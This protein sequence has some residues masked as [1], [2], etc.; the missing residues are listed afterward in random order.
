MALSYADLIEISREDSQQFTNRLSSL[1]G[2]SGFLK[3]LGLTRDSPVES[4]LFHE[5]TIN[6]WLKGKK[7]STARAAETHLRWWARQ[8]AK[9]LQ[10]QNLPTDRHKRMQAA[11]KHE[12]DRTGLTGKQLAAK[13]GIPYEKFMQWARGNTYPSTLA[14]AIKVEQVLDV[15]PGTLTASIRL[16]KRGQSFCPQEWLPEP[17]QG[18]SR[19]AQNLRTELR[20]SLPEN[21]PLLNRAEQERLIAQQV[22]RILDDTIRMHRRI[23]ARHQYGFNLDNAPERLKR[24]LDDF[25]TY[26][27]APVLTSGLKRPKRGL[28]RREATL[29]LWKRLF[30]SYFG[31]YLLPKQISYQA[32]SREARLLVGAGGTVEELTMGLFAVPTLVD[33]YLAWMTYV[34]SPAPTTAHASMMGQILSLL[35]AETGWITQNPNL[36]SRIPERHL[37]TYF[38]DHL[39]FLEKEASHANSLLRELDKARAR[40]EKDRQYE[41]V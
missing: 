23:V 19:S 18:S 13:A 1:A 31:W 7:P 34:R 8:Y 20:W 30:T 9:I 28:V 4:E 3:H 14:D 33:S 2:R 36:I 21:F 24:E 10:A 6:A 27:T 37:E 29:N 39:R 22:T 5:S 35:H 12:L 25:F 32:E 26:K 40:T 17:F 11:V 41:L 38:K 15:L 16:E